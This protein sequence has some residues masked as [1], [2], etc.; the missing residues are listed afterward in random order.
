[1]APVEPMPL[2]LLLL[3]ACV[4]SAEGVA[5]SACTGLG[6]AKHDWLVAG[7]SDPAAFSASTLPDGSVVYSLT[8]GVV[9]RELTAPF[10]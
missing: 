7:C 8:N 5:A 3:L 4:H 10:G 1:M 2:L 6:D 9:I